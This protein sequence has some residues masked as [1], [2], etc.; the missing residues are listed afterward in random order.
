MSPKPS[1]P[2]TML[3][4][5]PDLE[6]SR[7]AVLNS[8]GSANS[9]RAYDYA[10][11]KFLEWYCAEPRLG[12]NRSVVAR[13][14]SFLEQQHYSES[15]INL[16][17]GAVRRLASEAAD[18]GPL[19][20]D[21]A[22]G[23]RRVRGVKNLGARVRNWLT[24][25]QARGLLGA[26]GLATLQAKRDFALLGVL[27]RCGLRRA[28]LMAITV[29]DFEQRD[30]RWL[31]PDMRGKG[32]HI[33]TVPVPGWV[34]AAV[35]Q[36]TQAAGIVT[37]SV[38]RAVDKADRVRGDGIDAKVIWTIVRRRAQACGLEQIAPHDLPPDLRPP[39]S[40]S[41]RRTGTDSASARTS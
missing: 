26:I 38:F 41:G 29:G 9:R 32:G 30:G 15:T 21:L 34:K 36:W 35:D 31:L 27:F 8:L 23:I 1:V 22:A 37:G 17:L 13:Y 7:S 18:N 24:T 28:E 25:E 33:R 40:R 3:P 14:R 12:F 11:R 10:M 4:M 19:S 20:P 6:P 2:S 16:R 5:L 39:L